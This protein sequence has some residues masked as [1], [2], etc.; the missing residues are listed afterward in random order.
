[1]ANRR[2]SQAELTIANTILAEVRDRL[3]TAAGG[4]DALHFALRRK[5]FKE[6]GYDER[7]KPMARRALKA[8]K[9]RE[10]GGVCPLCAGPLPE[11]YCVLDRLEAIGGYVRENTRLICQPCDIDVQQK[12]GYR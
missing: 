4:D 3:K 8:L 11:R 10:Q 12:R 1:M 6:L 2:L 5:V 9:H 7:S